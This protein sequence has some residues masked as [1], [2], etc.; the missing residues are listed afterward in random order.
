MF[1]NDDTFY[2]LKHDNPYNYT[3]NNTISSSTP[4]FNELRCF[5]ES[6]SL[7]LMEWFHINCMQANPDKFQAI[8]VGKKT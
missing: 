6:E 8:T 4:N 3:D 1:I 7:T 5:L 2:F